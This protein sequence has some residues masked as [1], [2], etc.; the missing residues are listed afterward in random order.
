MSMS[1]MDGSNGIGMGM[2][3]GMGSSDMSRPYNQS[4]ARTY[5]Y[6]VA[7]LFLLACLLRGVSVVEARS[8]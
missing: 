5:W 3:M 2:D 6:L 4:L 1:G 8:R 7:T